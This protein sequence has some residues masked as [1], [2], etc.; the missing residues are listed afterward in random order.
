VAAITAVTTTPPPPGP[1]PVAAEATTQP[2]VRRNYK[3][4]FRVEPAFP[5]RAINAGVGGRVTVWLHVTAGGNVTEVEIR[6]SSNRMFDQEVVRALSQWRFN[7]EP[8]GFI[9]EYEIVFNLQG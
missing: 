4:S 5:K 8:V 6:K 1:P 3:A 2:V 9:G 7:P